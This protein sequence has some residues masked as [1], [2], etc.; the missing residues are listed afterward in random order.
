VHEDAKVCVTAALY[1]L[2]KC[3]CSKKTFEASHG[4]IAMSTAKKR[5][6]IMSFLGIRKPLAQS[7][8]PSPLPLSPTTAY[9]EFKR[10][11]DAE[12]EQDLVV[13][14]LEERLIDHQHQ[15]RSRI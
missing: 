6:A 4:M 13:T 11:R 5:N 3:R 7:S 10:V 15:V 9:T 2:A 12:M 8:A 14:A 1:S